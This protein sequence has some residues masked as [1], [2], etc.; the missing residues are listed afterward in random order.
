MKTNQDIRKEAQRILK[1]TDAEYDMQILDYSFDFLQRKG[2]AEIAP[3]LHTM[4]AYWIWWRNQFTICDAVFINH[5]K[6]FRWQRYD[7]ERLHAVY[8]EIHTGLKAYPSRILEKIEYEI[9]RKS[10]AASAA[11]TLA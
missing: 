11:N 9:R 5:Y 2:L 1:L 8:Y 6:V 4:R 10:K 7:C 3:T